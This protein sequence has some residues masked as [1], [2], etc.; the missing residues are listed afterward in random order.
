MDIISSPKFYG[1]LWKARYQAIERH[2]NLFHF[3]CHWLCHFT[4]GM[5]ELFSP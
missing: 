1:H 4:P 3:I 2:N 5:N